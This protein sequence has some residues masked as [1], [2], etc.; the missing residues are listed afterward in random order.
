[1]LHF[2][3]N[4]IRTLL[5][6]LFCMLIHSASQSQ[7]VFQKLN[8]P[9]SNIQSIVYC[10]TQDSL[11]NV[12]A[13]TEEGI[14]RFNSEETFLYDRF[15]GLPKNIS[16]RVKTLLVDSQQ[17][18]W[19]GTQEGLS[20][21][22]KEQDKF[23]FIQNPKSQHPSLVS[24]IIE[25]K[26]GEIWIGAFNGLWK[27]FLDKEKE[28]YQIQ[29]ISDIRR[30]NILF[31]NNENLLIGT[32]DKLQSFIF[33]SKQTT[34]IPTPSGKLRNVTAIWKNE[35]QYLFGTESNGLL[36]TDLSFSQIKKIN[37]PPFAKRA[38]PIKKILQDVSS[39]DFFIASD[40][41]GLMQLD[42]NLNFKNE[43]VNNVDNLNSISSNGVYDI[44]IG[45]EQILWI[46]TYGGG[47]NKLHLSDA[48]FQ[49]LTHQI[50][51]S[52]SIINN[53]TRAILEDSEGKIWFGT[54]S[55]ISIWNRKNQQ[56]ENILSLSGN[57]DIVM[58]LEEDGDFI[59]AGT[60]GNGA[61]KINKNN[62]EVK[63][64]SNA[65]GTD[66]RIEISRIYSIEKDK[67]GNIWLGGLGGELH[68]ITPSGNIRTFPII[69][70]RQIKEGVNGE[71]WVV[72]RN[73]LQKIQ[74]DE[75]SDFEQFNPRKN[76]VDY[77]TISC[78]RPNIDGSLTIGTSGGGV[79]FFQPNKN[80]LQILNQK[81][82]LPSDVVQGIIYENG[83]TLWASTS[84]GLVEIT[85]EKDTLIKVFNQSDGLVNS[86]FN[87]GSFT[88]IRSDELFFGGVNGVS[89]FQPNAI[90]SQNFSPKIIFEEIKL[91]N[92]DDAS[93]PT[94]LKSKIQS[95]SSIYLNY[96]ENSLRIKFVG[97]LHSAS[98][99]VKYS[100][101]MEGA[102][103]DWSPPSSENTVNF[104]N[105][106][107]GDYTFMVKA[108]NRDGVWS[109]VKQF[110]FEI[111][112][113]WWATT[114]AY[115]IY[116]VLSLAALFGA[117][118]LFTVFTNKKNAE[119]QIAF[120]SSITHELK[121]PLTI[122]LSTLESTNKDENETAS[123][124]KIKS[125]VK[126]LNTLFDQL[127]N[128]NK[129]ASGK[130]QEKQVAE[131]HMPTHLEHII[132][133][134]KPLLKKRNI[135][136]QVDDQWKK[137]IFYY[138]RDVLDKVLFN[139]ISNAI[140]YSNDGGGLEIILETDK[141]MDLKLSVADRGIGIPQDQQKY[142]LK[143]YYRG[144]NAIN[145]QL[146][147]T[148]LGLM[149]VKNLVERD[150]G[151]ISFESQQNKGTTFT[152]QLHDQK[153]DFD[154]L[155]FSN[156]NNEDDF[157]HESS[158][159]AEFSEAKIL[160][161]EDNDEL[162][163]LLV[164]RISTYFQVHEA[165]NG[166]EGLEKARE[167]FPDLVLT[168]FIMPE[169]N[170]MEMCE[171]LKTDINM[172]HIPIFMMTVLNSTQNK[173]ESIES[174]ITAYMEKPI[175]YNFLLA[176]IVSTLTRQK[177]LREKFLRQTDIKNAEK[178]RNKRD[179]DFI[180]N[181]EKFVLEQVKEEGLSVHDLCRE[182]GMS[183]TALYMK[184]KNMVDLSPQNFIIHT[185]LKYAR[186]LLMESD[187]NVKEV[188]YQVGFSNP[189][190]FS[191][192]FKKLFGQSP[193]GFL[194]SLESGEGE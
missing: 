54:K 155:L 48:F 177:V 112:P 55:G 50:N 185:R 91:L 83:N 29:K 63:Q 93:K 92:Q 129:V 111:T 76:T 46:T 170:G 152:V 168:D 156:N 20:K 74:G 190:Y 178:F 119:E 143:R 174:G 28:G 82:G 193:T 80:I 126:R 23:E 37:L 11:G 187:I 7:Q 42:E 154:P 24:S 165:S 8:S 66:V 118:Y 5:I 53:F 94:E 14:I 103:N 123:N 79:L 52:N 10:I 159:I 122:L 97:V 90:Q 19:I 32:D 84:R 169:M 184:L 85:L 171:V 104:S 105:L 49:N 116:F 145:S 137:D 57:S 75:I 44:F 71:I 133:S 191:T 69:Q 59:W 43:F 139:L 61:F 31:W 135:T 194:K 136:L 161:V 175:D 127:L 72:G 128:F 132:G 164:Q 41:A 166:K 38:F 64:Y 192:S 160:V 101:K 150:K 86:E 149:I 120:F 26:N 114:L 56:W 60:F 176:K 189:K 144:R 172:N 167:V 148:G 186:K 98:D 3:F 117:F 153:R 27:C 2:S 158:K 100:Y 65:K 36:Q 34:V 109:Q 58:S 25:G 15:K 146:P 108:T 142:I 70:I 35:N 121:T 33:N 141:K 151:I 9:T 62:L 30:I 77:N 21:Y 107:P 138:D 81:N 125:T 16:N 163:H 17:N 87:Y 106:R 179:A 45:R 18:I 4:Y 130:Y 6:F 134:F 113:P 181:L 140:K 147:G 51:D 124:K 96:D 182:V 180:N 1:M 73:G 78:I 162:R 110:S 22:N 188:A 40:G 89:Y 102:G 67:K 95:N 47:I 68:R 173:I 131:I 88:K 157:S 99:K 13:G 39:N 183:R 115:A 12:W